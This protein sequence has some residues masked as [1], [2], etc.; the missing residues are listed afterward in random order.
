MDR[1]MGTTQPSLFDMLAGALAGPPAGQIADQVGAET[2]A[3]Q[4]AIA[5]GLPLLISALARNASSRDGADSLTRALQKD[6]D[7]SVLSDLPSYVRGGGNTQDGQKI[8]GHVLGDQLGDA[9]AGIGKATGLDPDAVGRILAMIAPLVLGYLGREQSAR[10]LDPD[11]VSDLVK[12]EEKQIEKQPPSEM[13]QLLEV[14]LDRDQDG[15]ITDDAA[16]LGMKMLQ[17]WLLGRGR[18]PGG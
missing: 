9:Q 3:V 8:L 1:P 2:P 12:R 17:G 14:F 13:G 11:G 10:Q 7:G 18:T 4:Q 15:S 6:H 5:M 16:G